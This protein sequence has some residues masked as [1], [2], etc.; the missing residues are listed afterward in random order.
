[1]PAQTKEA[2]RKEMLAKRNSTS[3]SERVEKSAAITKR[4]L[5]L[6]Q[7]KT[8]RTIALYIPKGSE[9][10]VKPLILQAIADKEVLVPVTASDDSDDRMKFVKFTTF[11][12][13]APA[14]F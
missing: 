13:L 3:E 6:G 9:V 10:D 8:A 4:V 14:R 12:G 2:L 5:S 1:M 7:F 11:D